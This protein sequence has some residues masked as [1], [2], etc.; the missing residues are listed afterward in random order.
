MNKVTKFL[1]CGSVDDGKST[2]IGKLLFDAGLIYEDQL[3]SLRSE[4]EKNGKDINE[5]DYSFLLDGLISEREQGITID[6]AYRYFSL[7][8]KKY[9]VADTPG[10][11]QYTKNM[12]TGASHCDAGIILIDARKGL[13]LQTRR[14][15]LICAL[16][17]INT[18]LFAVNKCDL[19]NWDESLY[20]SIESD[21]IQL[22][23]DLSEIGLTDIE[24]TCTPISA[25]FGDNLLNRSNHMPWYSDSTVYEWLD[26]L[27][28]DS[29]RR[30]SASK[31]VVQYVVKS[32]AQ[33]NTYQLSA[34]ENLTANELKKFRAYSGKLL[35]GSMT[36]GQRV[37]VSSSEITTSVKGILK[38]SH[39]VHTANRGDSVSLILED[40]IDI[41]RGDV[42]VSENV[43]IAKYSDI[44]A[45]IIWMDNKPLQNNRNYVIKGTF[46][47]ANANIK[48]IDY[49]YNLESFQQIITNRLEMNEVGMVD[50]H[51]HSNIFLDE[52]KSEKQLGSFIIIDRLSNLTVGCGLINNLI[53]NES[54][55]NVP[56][57]KPFILWFT[58]LSGSGKT[59]TS[60]NLKFELTERGYNP[61]LLDGDVLR[62]GICSDLGFSDSDRSENIR[63][64]AEMAKLILNSGVIV[65][66]SLISPFE[67]D[68]QYA[69]ELL[70]D[71]QFIEVF[72][73]APL[74][75]CEKRDVK[76][77]YKKA[78]GGQITNFTGIGSGYETPTNPEIIV[79]TDKQSEPEVVSTILAFLEKRGL[80][81]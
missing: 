64:T 67:K 57:Q 29:S 8:D 48:R 27:E 21:C 34:I 62:K 43:D 77:F 22:I 31:F 11:T 58:G 5:I 79:N 74:E 54:A 32:F 25:L 66:C 69:R 73:N 26:K 15:A 75:V 12:A 1:T 61:V 14:H 2:M 60:E 42:I 40:E 47:Y 70:A 65:M 33:D 16:M 51:L 17:G 18:V 39:F 9:I 4:L 3:Q 13:G 63:R 35:A 28:F 81:E 20:R 53:D 38:G 71:Y 10:H 49:K 78:R 7:N 24:Y 55:E 50:I 80:L 68:R 45:T 30:S 23:N 52:Y 72:V 46:G 36:S 56:E 6:V 76:G 41:S 19:I 37:K 59:T 44:S